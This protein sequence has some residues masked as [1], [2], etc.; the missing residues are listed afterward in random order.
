M[1]G[2]LTISIQQE[3]DSAHIG[4]LEENSPDPNKVKR[5]LLFVLLS[6]AQHSKWGQLDLG[7]MSEV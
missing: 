6:F 3:I 5:V 2:Y 7:H 1:C 4:P